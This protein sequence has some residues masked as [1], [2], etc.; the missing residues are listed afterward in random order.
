VACGD[1]H[2]GNPAKGDAAVYRF[3]DLSCTGC[4]RDPHRGQ[5]ATR[6]DKKGPDGKLSGC[7]V[8]HTVETWK[9]LSKFDHSTTRFELVGS[10]RAV[11]CRD[12]HKP[13]KLEIT[14][15]NVDFSAAPE[16]CEG[17]H[18]DP[19]GAQFVR[20]GLRIECASCH[21]SNRWKPSL[22][23]HNTRTSF[24]L[25]GVH[26]NVRCTEC[27]KSTREVGGKKVLFYS[28][29]PRECAACHGPEV[30]KKTTA[31]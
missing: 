8:C 23:D 19:H 11:A 10:H 21:N 1:C 9:D 29:T 13:P 24:K 12:C 2:K 30:L 31:Q 17:C 22:F 3:T 5:F 4:H 27:H 7:L 14:L 28:P 26:A 6:M 16:Q 25:E 20:S 18:E 15:L